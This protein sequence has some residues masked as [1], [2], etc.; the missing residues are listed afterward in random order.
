MQKNNFVL[1][2][3][4]LVRYFHVQSVVYVAVH[5]EKSCKIKTNLSKNI[6]PQQ[7]KHL[8]LRYTLNLNNVVHEYSNFNNVYIT[9][10]IKTNKI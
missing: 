9:I 2:Y 8:I 1:N 6:S 7:V 10:T 4:H 5:M 3:C